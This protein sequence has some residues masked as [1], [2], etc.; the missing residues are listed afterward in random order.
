MKIIDSNGVEIASPDLT[1]GYLKPETQTVHHDAVAGVEEVSHYETE[2]LPDGTPAI[3]Y[4]ADGREK[5]RDVR[6]VVDV[7]GVIAQKAYDE[8][9]EVQRYVLYT[10]EE[11]AAQAEAKKKAEEAAA[12]EAKKKAELETV[13]GRMDA[14][15]AANDDLVL[16]MADL[17]G[18]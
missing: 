17:I 6:K 8:E 2:T 12:A 18:G 9:V 4:D 15:E 13:P 14:L 16:M 3:Y 10:A 11:L 5:G 1:K 7:P